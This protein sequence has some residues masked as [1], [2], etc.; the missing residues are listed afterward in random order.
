MAQLR[1]EIIGTI[2]SSKVPK[3]NLSCE[4]QKALK[5]LKKEESIIILPSDK[6]RAS[7]VMDKEDYENKIKIMLDDEKTYEKLSKDPTKAYKSQ[8][9]RTLTRLRNEN[10]INQKDYDHLYPAS[11]CVPRMYFM[12][13]I[14]KPGT[15]L[16]P[17]VDYTSSI[18]YATSR[19]MADILAPLSHDVV[20]LFT[21]VPINETL[22]IIKERLE[23]DRDLNKRTLLTVDDLMELLKFLCTTTYFVFRGQIHRQWF[24]TAMSSPVLAIIAEFC[25][26]FLEQKFIATAPI[27]CR[28]KLRK[29]YV[30]DVLEIIKDGKVDQLTHHLNQ[31]EFTG[32]IKFTHKPDN[33]IP[34]LDMLITR[35]PDGSVKLLIYRKPTH[36]HQY[37]NF[38]SH[39]PLQHKL[40]VV[41]TLMDRAEWVVTD[42]ED[43]K[44]EEDHIKTGSPQM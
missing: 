13:K 17:I 39:H 34:F 9:I 29:R 42:P 35:K 2:K 36:T 33:Q 32:N 21:N 37:L 19:S 15:P 44:K 26:E 11:E 41:R 10:K 12:P 5:D 20:S 38:T 16:R 31:A 3:S 30:N 4:E 23:S 43:C 24:G 28:P 25:M 1:I 22:N 18:G 6:G 8:L 7:V 40:G 14:H 27:D